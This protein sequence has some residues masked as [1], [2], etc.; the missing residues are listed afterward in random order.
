MADYG[1]LS[2]LDREALIAG[3][4]VDVAPYKKDPADFVLW[5]P[6]TAEQPGWASPWGRRRPGWHIECSAMALEHLGEVF[7]IHGGGLALVFPHHENQ[8]AQSRSAHGPA[9]TARLRTH[10]GYVVV[11]GETM[12]RSL[13]D[14]FSARH[15]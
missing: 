7:D 3:A 2:R 5:K 8:I 4:R 13:G 11:N 14:S 12:S 6:S 10:N 1:Q 15:R 9:A